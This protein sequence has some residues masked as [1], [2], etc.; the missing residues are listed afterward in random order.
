MNSPYRIVTQGKPLE[1][2]L[3]GSTGSNTPSDLAQYSDRLIR[4]IPSE[5]IGFYLVGSGVIPETNKEA[6]GIWAVICFI[7]VIVTRIYGTKSVNDTSPQWKTVFISSVSFWIW[8]YQ[9]GGPFT[10]YGIHVPW[11]GSLIMLSW[12]FFI[13]FVYKGQIE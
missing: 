8:L 12:T 4:L 10:S 3:N 6:M 13:P 11:I 1:L 9:I 5:V 7:A 2:A